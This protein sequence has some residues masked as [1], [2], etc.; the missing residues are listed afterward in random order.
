MSKPLN[1]MLVEDDEDIAFLIRTNILKDFPH[2]TFHYTKTEE[3]TLTLLKEL[4]YD[5]DVLLLDYLLGDVTGLDI[6][7]KVRKITD[8]PAIIITG[9]GSEEIAVKAMKLGATDYIV[10]KGGFFTQIPLEIQKVINAEQKYDLSKIFVAFYRFGSSG[11]ELIHISSLPN[12]LEKDKD[13]VVLPLGVLL[14][15]LFGMGEV[16]KLE[17]GSVISGPV[18]IPKMKDYTATSFFYIVSDDKQKDLR[19]SGKDYCI[20]ALGYP[21][22]YS[23]LAQEVEKIKHILN[24]FFEDITDIREV[25]GKAAIVKTQIDNIIKRMRN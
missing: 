19:L 23:E 25:E 11:T 22:F 6:L 8:I 10:K 24:D 17:S 16:D 1:I 4:N 21:M 14:F 2:A 15:T 18:R 12:E 9:Q 13:N 5:I 20:V 3:Q 7:T